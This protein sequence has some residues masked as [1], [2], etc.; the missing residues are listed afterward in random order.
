MSEFIHQKNPVR[1]PVPG[2]KTI[3][4][5]FGLLANSVSTF[6][7][8]RMIAPPEWGEPWQAPD[9]DELTLM[10]RGKIQVETDQGTYVLS[11]G[12]SF[13]SG[14]GNRVRY[15]NPF[16]AESEYWAVCIPAFTPG[17]ANRDE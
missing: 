16:H 7:V 9:F 6:S 14:R 4:E 17:A 8:A 3:L 2:N 5:H 11:A 13:F 12:D 1:I 10:V 15:S